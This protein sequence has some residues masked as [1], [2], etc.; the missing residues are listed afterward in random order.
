MIIPNWG[1]IGGS[2]LFAVIGVYFKLLTGAYFSS[3]CTL[4][5]NAGTCIAAES[6]RMNSPITYTSCC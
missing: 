5:C 3:N 2:T 4:T 1:K 6:K